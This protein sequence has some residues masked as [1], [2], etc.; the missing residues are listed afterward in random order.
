MK[1][2]GCILI[3]FNAALFKVSESNSLTKFTG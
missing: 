2:V 1:Q 3:I